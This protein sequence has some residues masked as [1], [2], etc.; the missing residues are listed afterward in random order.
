MAKSLPV[1]NPLGYLGVK[2][3]SP[4]EVYH[5][6]RAPTATDYRFD[7]G[8]IW[9]DDASND[10]WMMS[11]KSGPTATWIQ[12]GHATGTLN[13]LTSDAGISTPVA[14]N[15]NVVGGANVSTTAAGDTLTVAL[16]ADINV[17]SVTAATAD[18]N[19]GTIDAVTIGTA[20]P[21]T[22]AMVDNLEINAN[23]VYHS[24]GATNSISFNG[25][26]VITGSIDLATGTDFTI[27]NGPIQGC[28]ILTLYGYNDN[29]VP[30]SIVHMVK[31][32]FATNIVVTNEL[33]GATGAVYTVTWP[34][35]GSLKPTFQ[36][37]CGVNKTITYKLV[38]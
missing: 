22:L 26:N 17:N 23:Y 29:D 34:L 15:I 13:T 9:I 10:I 19:G 3:N 4:P 25:L 2:E 24:S 32:Q 6:G 36:H 21:C 35:A 38:W 27:A 30:L 12:V 14:G 33:V 5:A 37:D 7:T 11:Y 28:C 20:S 31:R 1:G 16:E 18:I 8:D